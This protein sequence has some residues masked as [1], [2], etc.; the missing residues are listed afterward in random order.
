MANDFSAIPVGDI[1]F[2]DNITPAFL[3]GNYE[4]HVEQLLTGI[5]TGQIGDVQN[6]TVAAPQVTIDTVDVNTTYP[7]QNLTG[8][9]GDVLPHIVLNMP[10]LPW[11]RAMDAND[12]TIPWMALL[13][14]SPDELLGDSTFTTKINPT[15]V[16]AYMST[17]PSN[18]YRPT[19]TPD[20][21]VVGTNAM[22][23]VQMPTALFNQI[24]P[25]KD[26]LK[27][28]THVRALNMGDKAV[29]GLTGSG[30]YA[31]VVAN[32]FPAASTTDPLGQQN[33]VHLVSLEG[34]QNYLT[35]SANFGTGKD[36]LELI[37]LYSWTFRTLPDP[38][39]DFQ[40]LMQAMVASEGPSGAQD[41]SKLWLRLD[42]SA[43][44]A[45]NA[46]DRIAAGYV[47]LNYLT[48]SGEHTFA[49]YRGPFAPFLPT[50]FVAPAAFPTADAAVI[51]DATNG[52]FD[53]SLAT[54][55][56][57]G[58]AM[59]LADQSFG[60][61]LT[62]LRRKANFAVDQMQYLR[63]MVGEDAAMA[64]VKARSSNIFNSQFDLLLQNNVVAAVGSPANEVHGGANGATTQVMMGN[65]TTTDE[66][67]VQALKTL[68]DDPDV[69]AA[70]AVAIADEL[71]PVVQWLVN[72]ALL[73]NVP[74]NNIVAD[75]R[76][77]PEES[78]RFFYMD[79][80]WMS[81]LRDGALSIAQ[82][83]SRDTLQASKLRTLLDQAVA[84]AMAQYRDRLLGQAS[85]PSADGI[86]HISGFMMRSAVVSGWPGLS[87][88]GL[89]ADGKPLK[90]LRQD[91]LSS[92]VLLVLFWGA[93]TQLLLTEPQEGFRFGVN[94]DGEIELRNL[95]AGSTLGDALRP[96][97]IRNME[98]S[99]GLYMRAG[100]QARVLNL[101]PQSNSGLIN[102][103][104]LEI[105][106][107]S[108]SPAGF[109]I[110]MVNAP[111]QQTFLPPK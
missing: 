95:T 111:M 92:D 110:Q 52:I 106:A 87:V 74:F 80:N 28:L 24:A 83:S 37:S 67:P 60:V 39:A 21:D 17:P 72:L 109:A 97:P 38:S 30:L 10:L 44:A 101:S 19:I 15:T 57:T 103:I 66:N 34:M 27:Y 13:V 8:L 107:G 81:A 76:L 50:N 59:A 61:N 88:Q 16:A 82:Q 84:T 71:A 85:E 68:M 98:G 22:N 33:I 45:G 108:L 79:D 42:G 64:Y 105:H 62:N 91:H 56:Q 55:W 25:H 9:Y 75:A 46:K 63:S 53:L 6:F 5:D 12:K 69:Q 47:P 43:L 32:R 90:V 48:R 73:Y 41:P 7:P 18:V 35:G 58:R 40:G 77:F 2:L 104:A 23:T 89:D 20:G 70:I 49:W 14:F 1:Q 54:A 102:A 3:A 99:D 86:T 31:V 11:E 93:P 78:L 96:F 26:E 51:Y 4:I 100:T 94:Q 65:A 29:D 36:T